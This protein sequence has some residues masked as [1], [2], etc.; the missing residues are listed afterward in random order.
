V[1]V[2]AP[3]GTARTRAVTTGRHLEGDRVEIL[4]G[5]DGGESVAVDASGPVADGTPLEVAP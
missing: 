4:S 2:R 5:L 3:D 1:I